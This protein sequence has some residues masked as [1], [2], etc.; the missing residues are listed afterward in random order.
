MRNQSLRTLAV[1]VLACVATTSAVAG[2]LNFDDIDAGQS[3]VPMTA[4]YGGFT[5]GVGQ[6]YLDPDVDYAS[7]GNTYGAVSSPNAAF[8]DNGVLLVIVS[9]GVPF[10][11][12]GAYFTTWASQNA[13]ESF[14]STSIAV[15]GYLNSVLVGSTSMNLS[16][17]GYDWL[18]AGFASVD[19]LRFSASSAS[20]YWLMDNFTYQETGAVPEPASAMLLGGG[21]VTL[22]LAARRKRRS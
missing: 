14:S 10:A 7:Y 2:V 22:A 9:R 11:F 3:G 8:N 19:E 16:P 18:N 12:D 4:G 13:F 1:L 17:T 6:W 20:T 5:W 21:L 15:E